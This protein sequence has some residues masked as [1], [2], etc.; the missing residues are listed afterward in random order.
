M[1][2]ESICRKCF[3]FYVCEQFNEHQDDK[4]KKC[5]F[6]ND[7]FVPTADVVEVVRC[8]DCKYF[9]PKENLTDEYDN[10]LGADGLCDNC[11]KYTD[12]NDFCSCGG[13]RTDNERQ[14]YRVIKW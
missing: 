8:K 1:A 5:H 11:D 13:R 3:H 6:F 4:N 14:A 10:P 12:A 7:H 2:E 9:I